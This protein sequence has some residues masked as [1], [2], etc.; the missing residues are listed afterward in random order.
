MQIKNLFR[1]RISPSLLVVAVVLGMALA[2]AASVV[3]TTVG[4]NVTVSGTVAASATTGSSSVTHA[5]G[6]GTSTPGIYFS[7]GGAGTDTTGH[8][9]FTGGLGVGRA[10][11]TSGNLELTGSAYVSGD[12]SVTDDLLVASGL[13]V[14]LGTTTTGMIENSANA[15]FGDAAAD[16]VMYN[17]ASHVYN[18]AGTSTILAAS[19]K[20]WSIATSSANIPFLR[21]NTSSYRIGLGTTTPGATLSVVGDAYVLNGLGVGLATTSIGT[22]QNSG[23]TLLGDA[24]ADLVM[25]NAASLILNNSGTTTIIAASEKSWSIATSSANI[26]FL[27]Y[28]TSAY[29]IGLGTTTPG[30]TFSVVGDAYVLNGLGVGLATTSIG[31]IENSGNTL[32]GDA[33]GDFVSLN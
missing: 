10:T 25:L 14:G 27:R 18:N 11:T 22:I 32:L 23:N 28:D 21:Y 24:A 6:V 8:G 4:T 9:Y 26:P 17:A 2:M 33:A 16:L 13:G 12:L 30:A 3:A 7:V 29:R 20:A 31:T 5:F 19:E 1:G 15:L